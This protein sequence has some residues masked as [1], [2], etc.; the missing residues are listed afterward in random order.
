MLGNRK[1]YML[2]Q[3]IRKAEMQEKETRETED[4]RPR[5]AA[6]E[7]TTPRSIKTTITIYNAFTH[8]LGIVHYG[9]VRIKNDS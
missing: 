1:G 2:W 8:Q 9:F 7:K 6:R 3:P 5:N 4:I